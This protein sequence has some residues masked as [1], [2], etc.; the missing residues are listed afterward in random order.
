MKLFKKLFCEIKTTSNK[1]SSTVTTSSS[2]ILLNYKN[3]FFMKKLENA[4]SKS[5]NLHST[6]NTDIIFQTFWSDFLH[7]SFFNKNKTYE[8]SDLLA[9]SSLDFANYNDDSYIIFQNEKDFIDYESQR[10]SA[11]ETNFTYNLSETD[12]KEIN[13]STDNN[14]SLDE[15]CLITRIPQEFNIDVEADGDVRIINSG[16]SKLIADKKI[17]INF[18]ETKDLSYPNIFEGK[19]LRT[20]NFFLDGKNRML[21]VTIK[22]YLEAKKIFF[23]ILNSSKI[24]I[25]KLGVV[26]EGI[27]NLNNCEADIR[28]IYGPVKDNEQL[29]FNIKNTNLM[30]GSVQG[31]IKILSEEFSKITIENLECNNFFFK[32]S[33]KDEISE[34]EIFIN[35]VKNSLKIEGEGIKIIL[36]LNLDSQVKFSVRHNE[37]FIYNNY[38]N[39]ESTGGDSSKIIE[40][41][42]N[43][44]PEIIEITSWEYMKRKIER[45]IKSKSQH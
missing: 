7:L 38:V 40:I 11:D 14:N 23:Q 24:R 37:S 17:K 42:S 21:Y 35:N 27:F 33:N 9:K 43:S 39:S 45:K 32:S 13:F 19:R 3:I 18:T 2:K 8:N 30:V 20:E 12:E 1:A 31:N 34:L 4:R 25:K 28:S 41:K 29:E 6:T 5:I 26:N 36:Y 16:D 10:N 15:K 44:I 22:S